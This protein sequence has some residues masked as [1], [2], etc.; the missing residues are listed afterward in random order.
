MSIALAPLPPP[1]LKPYKSLPNEELAERI[2]AVKK[3]LG[4]RLLSLGH[5]Y[6]QDEVIV[7]SDLQGDSYQ[8]SRMAADR[9]SS[10]ISVRSNALACR[11]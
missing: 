9:T 3:E 5:H 7:H 10:Y 6:Q 4:P 1:D 11:D 2:E 8:L